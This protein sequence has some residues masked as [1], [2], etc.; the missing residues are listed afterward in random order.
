MLTTLL[1][2][3]NGLDME[4]NFS[5]NLLD[6]ATIWFAMSNPFYIGIQFPSGLVNL[7]HDLYYTLFKTTPQENHPVSSGKRHD[8]CVQFQHC[9]EGQCPALEFCFVFKLHSQ[10]YSYTE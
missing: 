5:V 8:L 7:F 2:N 6:P 10:S 4:C 1:S 3:M 9:P